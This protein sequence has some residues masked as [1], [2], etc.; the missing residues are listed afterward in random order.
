[1]P[2]RHWVAMLIKYDP[3]TK[4]LGQSVQPA[5]LVSDPKNK[6]LDHPIELTVHLTQFSHLIGCLFDA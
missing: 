3:T 4:L 5:L 1:M 6:I 2:R